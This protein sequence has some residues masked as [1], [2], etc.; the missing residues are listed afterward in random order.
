MPTTPLL[1]ALPR[2]D[3]PGVNIRPVTLIKRLP[4]ARLLV[5]DDEGYEH[6]VCDYQTWATPDGYGDSVQLAYTIERAVTR[7]LRVAA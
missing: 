2:P 6:E 3:G 5:R 7:T 4:D 1:A